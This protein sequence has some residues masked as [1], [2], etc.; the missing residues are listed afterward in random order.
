MVVG[1]TAS[2]GPNNRL[3]LAGMN[4]SGLRKRRWAG[5]LA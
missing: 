1:V 3:K 4:I 2:F 5:S